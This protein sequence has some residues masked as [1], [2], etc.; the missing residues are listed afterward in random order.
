MSSLIN[1]LQKMNQYQLITYVAVNFILL[2]MFIY[3]CRKE[4]LDVL[5]KIDNK[6]YLILF[7]ILGIE[8]FIHTFVV[9]PKHIVYV[10]EFQY[11]GAAKN[12]LMKGNFGLYP[13]SVGWPFLISIG[14]LLFGINNYVAIF[15]ATLL[16]ALT[17]FN[18]F[19]ITFI[20]SKDKYIALTSSALFAFLPPKIFW[21]ATAENHIPALFFVTLFLFFALL[22]YKERKKNLLWLCLMTLSFSSQVRVENF[23]YGI[24]F[25][26][27]LYIFRKP[28]IKLNYSFFTPC[29]VAISLCIVN[30]VGVLRFQL[31]TNWLESESGGTIKGSSV[32]LTNLAYNSLHWAPKL[33]DASLHPL[34]LSFFIILGVLYLL[35]VKRKYAIFLLFWFLLLFVFYFSIWFQVYGSSFLLFPKTRLFIFFYP[36]LAIFGAYGIWMFSLIFKKGVFRMMSVV[37]VIVVL[38]RFIPYYD[39]YPVRKASFELET[40]LVGN[41][42]KYV[43]SGCTIITQFPSIVNSVNSYKVVKT[44]LFLNDKN[45]Q[46]NVFASS[47]CILFWEDIGCLMYAKETIKEI[48]ERFIVKP[49]CAFRRGNIVSSFYTVEKK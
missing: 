38:L 19:L 34:T 3:F 31:G 2:V 17:F 35:R 22:Y 29:F 24:L 46:N 15:L 39:D 44:E 23:L 43:P 4:L 11:M 8:I 28:K 49:F 18:I 1:F 9:S 7:I 48:K 45:I 10:D 37:F 20:I 33:L 12:V 32:G 40:E 21:S 14:F 41:I 30:L 16:G 5:R 26:V 42:K 6:T 36:V 13:K 25:I 47:S 27:G